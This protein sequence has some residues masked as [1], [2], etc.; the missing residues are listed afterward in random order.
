MFRRILIIA[1]IALPALL[2]VLAAGLWLLLPRLDLAGFV[3]GRLSASFGRPVAIAT[4]QVTP[5]RWLRLQASGLTLENLPGGSRPLMAE[6]A[7]AEAE[8]DLVSLLSGAPVLRG[9][10]LAGFKLLL[11]H[12]GGGRANWKFATT[13]PDASRRDARDKVPTLLAAVLRDADIDIH[14]TRGAKL[15]LRIDVAE[16][17]ATDAASPMRLTASGRYR[18][19]PLA[20]EATLG[21][22]AA[23]RDT[24]RPYATDLRFTSGE[25]RLRFDGRM[26]DPLAL[27]AALGTLT[28][29]APDPRA[30]LAMAGIDSALE[31]PV[32]LE[33]Q[34]LHRTPL[35]EVTGGRGALGAS[36]FGNAVLRLQEGGA[37]Q[38]D[39]LNIAIDFER[40]DLNA[41]LAAREG[42][43]READLP[44]TVN[45]APG[46]L[47]TLRLSA[48]QF[49][50]AG[51]RATEARL[52]AAQTAGRIAV[53]ELFL[54]YQGG[55]L[56]AEGEVAGRPAEPGGRVTARVDATGLDV[57]VLARSLGLG[58][59][60]LLG[61]LDGRFAV[62][63]EAATLNAAVRGAHAS[64]VVAMRGGSI[65]RNVIEMAS[66][67]LR[68]LLRSAPGMSPVRCMVGVLDLRGG[69]GT[70]SPLRIRAEHGTIAGQGRFDLRRRQLDLLVSSESATTSAFAL[71]VPVRVTGA[72]ADPQIAPAQ[73][74]PG[75][76][77]LL[78]EGDE[79]GRLL[80]DLQP[81][82]RRSP[83]LSRARGR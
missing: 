46:T 19:V 38:P 78:A 67:D 65:A 83:C 29:A 24:T 44:L 3:A 12:A 32:Q 20:L 15:T 68:G 36:P 27:D 48:K 23:L 35:W 69:A 62:E 5:G 50:Y 73:W 49:A 16:V 63:G 10:S 80:P 51:L 79:V 42:E 77:A 33:G 59:L 61:R 39:D 6:L 82:A 34:L 21:S 25:T 56:R 9:V 53:P 58:A 45:P 4:L 55:Q 71:D 72:F 75:G 76:R 37:E 31:P 81:F 43:P 74:S 8:L 22:F 40:L 30:L 52:Q 1:A 26:E 70:V 7:S 13:L 41:L 17:A 28:L 60:P 66:T 47:I 54:G 64:A 57:Q 18:D 14:T 2:L 11:E